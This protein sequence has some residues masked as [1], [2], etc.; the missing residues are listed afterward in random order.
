MND[1][2]NDERNAKFIS[3]WNEE[4]LASELKKISKQYNQTYK[5]KKM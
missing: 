2:I 1:N 4:M 5:L 3:L